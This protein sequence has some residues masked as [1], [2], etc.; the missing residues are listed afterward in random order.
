M[1]PPCSVPMPTLA[2]GWLMMGDPL[3]DPPLVHRSER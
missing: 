1:S 3:A 2:G